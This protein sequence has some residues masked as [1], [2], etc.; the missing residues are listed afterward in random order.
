MGR[1]SGMKTRLVHS[2]SLMIIGMVVLGKSVNVSAEPFIVE[3]KEEI[4]LGE[5]GGEDITWTVLRADKGKALIVSKYGLDL[6]PFNESGEEALWEDCSL[7]QWLNEEFYTEA[8]SKEE[9][10]MI[11]KT[12]V[13]AEDSYWADIDGGNDTE[14]YVFL[15]SASETLKYMSEWERECYLTEYASSKDDRY[16]SYSTQDWLLR[17]P[18]RYLD[19][20]EFVL[21]D[22]TLHGFSSNYIFSETGE[23]CGFGGGYYHPMDVEVAIRPAM[24][25]SARP[26][27]SSIYGSWDGDLHQT[28]EEIKNIIESDHYDMWN[29]LMWSGLNSDTEDNIRS[30]YF[31]SKIL[32][33]CY[34]EWQNREGITVEW[35]EY[36][37]GNETSFYS[38]E[39]IY[40][41]VKNFTGKAIHPVMIIVD[42]FG[43]LKTEL[44]DNL[45]NMYNS[46]NHLTF[47]NE[48]PS[49]D[50]Y[51]FLF[52]E[53]TGELLT[54]SRIWIET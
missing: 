16:D 20:P 11:Q 7:R 49:G 46:N 24:I 35:Y 22:G 47:N 21:G 5:Y 40:Y 39:T 38:P 12:T 31:D 26:K 9:Q 6:Q 13:P 8:F 19:E 3:E 50:L 15:L 36:E 23:I 29:Q 28:Y 2:I 4:V 10:E 43:S 32:D 44:V 48:S 41:T 18:S 53:Y 17:S 52:D 30:L 33:E 54:I 34:S 45:P 1:K 51:G 27:Y 25:I 14:D 42:S 37:N